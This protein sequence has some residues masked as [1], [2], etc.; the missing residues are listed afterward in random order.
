M[1]ISSACGLRL[2]AWQADTV[3]FRCCRPKG[4]FIQPNISTYKTRV[5]NPVTLCNLN[6]IG[7]TIMA[8]AFR[9]RRSGALNFD[10][11]S[12]FGSASS[13]LDRFQRPNCLRHFRIR[14]HQMDLPVERVREFRTGLLAM[15][16]ARGSSGEIP[17]DPRAPAARMASPQPSVR[18]TVP[19]PTRDDNCGRGC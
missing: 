14:V 16:A 12:V 18:S 8:G 1:L 2:P 4:E 19:H 13:S 7:P 5:L 6:R 3:I 15:T 9:R 10:C 11:F 17:T